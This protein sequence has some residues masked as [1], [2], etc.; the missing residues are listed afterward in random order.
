MERV[1]IVVQ[2][3]EIVMTNECVYESYKLQ[4]EQ[5]EPERRIQD[6]KYDGK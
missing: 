2:I 5:N 3:T 4:S 6:Q 1:V